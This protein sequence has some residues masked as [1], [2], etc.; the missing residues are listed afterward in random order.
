MGYLLCGLDSKRTF[1]RTVI[2]GKSLVESSKPSGT[3]PGLWMTDP[4]IEVGG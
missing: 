2:V 3:K 1:Y 4:R